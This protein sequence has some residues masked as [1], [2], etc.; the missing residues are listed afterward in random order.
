MGDDMIEAVRPGEYDEV[1]TKGRLAFYL[2]GKIKGEYLLTAAADTGED[3]LKKLFDDLDSQDPRQIL[4]RLDPDDY[5]PVY[6]DDSTFVEDAPTKGKFYVRLERGDSH[7]MWGNYKTEIRGTEFLRSERA[8][9]GASAVYRSDGTTSFGERRTE[10]TAYAAQPD[11]LPAREEFLGTGGSAYF[12]KRQD[13]VEG[14]ETVTIETRDP[15]TGRVTSRRVLAYGEDYSFDYMQGVLLLTEPVTSMTGTDGPVRSSALGGGKQY[16]VM[17]Y[18]FEPVASD[19]DGYVYGGRVQHWITDNVRVGVTGMD[20]STE[21]ADQ[22][23]YG[24][25]IVLR[26]TDETYLAAEVAKSKGRGFNYSTSTDGGLSLGTDGETFDPGADEGLAWSVEGKVNLQD[27]GSPL[28]GRLGAYY[29]EKERGFSTLHNYVAAD[30]RM[31]GA[32]AEL[33]VSPSITLGLGYDDFSADDGR[34]KRDGIGTVS[35]AFDRH[36]EISFGVSYTD[37]MSPNAVRSGK[38][39]YDGSRFDGGVRVDYRFN[40]DRLV[41][42]FGQGTIDRSGDIDRNDRGGIGTKVRLTDRIGLEGEVSYGTH[43][44]G[45]LAGLTYDPT[46]D[47]HYYLGYRLD[48]DRAFDLDRN[49][50]LFGTDKGVVVAGLR[51]KIS[52]FASAYNESNYDMFGERKTLTQ[53]YGVIYTPDEAWTVDAGLEIGRVQDDTVNSAGVENEDFDRY[54]PSLAL[55][56]KNEESGLTARLRGEVRIERSDNA[57]RDQN[58]YLFTGGVSWKAGESGRLIAKIDAVLSDSQSASTSFADTDYVET[59]VGYAWRPVDNDRLNALF[60]YTWLYD[61]PGNN[62]LIGAAT[63]DMYAPAQRSH[64]LS[65]DANFDVTP[66][67]TLGAKYGFRIGE[68]RY[69]TNGGAGTTFENEWQESSAHLGILRADLHMI[70]RW[71]LLLEGRVLHMPEA[72]TTEYGALAAVYRHVGNNFKVGV[73][74][75]FGRFSDDLRDLTLDDQGVF[76]NLVGKF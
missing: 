37:L 53:T 18:E 5:Y 17:H 11:T 22:Q 57:S 45:A 12:L 29:E 43:G 56:Y 75:N 13:I 63:G 51:R 34:V 21:A 62:Q 73:G 24:A 76:L 71:D 46:A 16:V 60:K 1:Y 19:V 41:Y 72:D 44:L 8:L 54:S 28:Q 50:D 38:S 9:Y 23:A 30:Q 68:V 48:P 3:D 59:S 66:W 74:Y 39:G 64:I 10:V 67:L 49:Y 40:D 52:E 2:K 6:G 4:R 42:A 36:W 31:W 61:L 32:D 65:A 25:D 7:V 15:V 35:Y 69:R 70:K 47:D 26:R 14:S 58:T 33:A 27:L 20:D 55:A